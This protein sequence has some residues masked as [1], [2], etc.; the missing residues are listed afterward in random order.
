MFLPHV[1]HQLGQ[2]RHEGRLTRRI[3]PELEF[4]EALTVGVSRLGHQLPRLLGV[5]GEGVQAR[6]VTQ[7][8]DAHPGVAGDG[9]RR[10]TAVEAV[11]D[12]FL[13]QGVVEGMTDCLAVAGMFRL[14]AAHGD[15]EYVD[16]LPGVDNSAAGILHLFRHCQVDLGDVGLTSPEGRHPDG[17]LRHQPQIQ[18]L[19]PDPTVLVQTVIRM[20]V[21]L[22]KAFDQDL[23]VGLDID[24]AEWTGANG[25]IGKSLPACIRVSFRTTR[26]IVGFGHQHTG[27]TPAQVRHVAEGEERLGLVV[28]YRY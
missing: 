22:I 27:E 24:H 11:H 4:G 21:V 19:E 8:A 26:F 20:V 23:L 16:A 15:V 3:G 1:R 2:F 13:V 5:E 10:G 25:G 28:G 7:G 9:C 17:R 14:P 18:G 12:G 6:L